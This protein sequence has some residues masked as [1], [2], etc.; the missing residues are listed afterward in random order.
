MKLDMHLHTQFSFQGDVDR[1]PTDSTIRLTEIPEILRQKGLDGAVI[2]D[3]MTIEAGNDEFES[4]KKDNPDIVLLRGMEYGS[5]MGHLLLYGIDNDDVCREFGAYGPAQDVINFVQKQ[6]GAVV[7]PHPYISGYTKI[8]KDNIFTLQDFFAVET[9]NG[10]CSDRINDLGEVAAL[11]L[12]LPQ[13]G[14]S[15]AHHPFHIGQTYTDFINPV[16]T[17]SD[18][19]QELQR[20]KYVPRIDTK[21]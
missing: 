8:M 6:G 7:I 19:V 18:L 17:I 15:D 16:F 9:K 1:R 11:S 2:T 5:D 3:H 21:R 10:Q 14:G 12:G 13:T 4:V 20:G